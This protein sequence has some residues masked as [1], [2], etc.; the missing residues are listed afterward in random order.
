MTVFEPWTSSA[1]CTYNFNFLTLTIW[2]KKINKNL[3]PKYLRLRVFHITN[4]LRNFNNRCQ[5]KAMRTFLTRKW[6]KLF[7]ILH[8]MKR[9]DVFEFRAMYSSYEEFVSNMMFPCILRLIH[10]IWY[11]VSIIVYHSLWCIHHSLWCI[12]RSLWCIHHS[13]IIILCCIIATMLND[14]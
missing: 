13:L 14:A 10:H 4:A 11:N 1:S 3:N 6:S 5:A 9:S 2:R 7:T 12:H 8:F